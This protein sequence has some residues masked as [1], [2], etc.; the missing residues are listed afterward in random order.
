MCTDMF[1]ADIGIKYV[2]DN[3]KQ[4]LYKYKGADNYQATNVVLPNGAFDPWH[5]LGTYNNDTANHM[6]PLLIQGNALALFSFELIVSG[7]A[8]CS[9]MY[10]T[11]PGEPTD[12][13]KNRAIIHNELKYFLGIS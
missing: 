12:L 3:N 6:T 8:H 10:P 4:T 13:A 5:V 7:A 9:D 11:Y 1:G 2:R